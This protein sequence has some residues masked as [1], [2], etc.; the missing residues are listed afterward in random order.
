[1][2]IPNS[3][4]TNQEGMAVSTSDTAAP[5][6]NTAASL[7]YAAAG[8]GINHLIAGVYWSYSGGTPT[9]GNLQISDGSNVIFNM[10]I[11]AAGPGYVPFDPPK[12]GTANTSLTITLAAGGASVSGKVNATHWTEGPGP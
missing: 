7:T 4:N 8:A 2:S 1:M 12:K 9:G 5:A 10:D 6:A 3:I 11:T